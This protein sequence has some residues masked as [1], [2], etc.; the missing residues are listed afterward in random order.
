MKKL[1]ACLAILV[2]VPLLMASQKDV[3]KQAYDPDARVN[4][5]PRIAPRPIDDSRALGDLLMTISLAAI[6]VP[7][8]GFS[9][10]GLTWDGSYLYYEN[11]T[12]HTMYVID[13]T[14]PS[15]VTSW[16]TGITHPWGVGS[17]VNM[18]VTDAVGSPG[19]IYEYTWAGTPTGNSFMSLSGGAVWMGDVSEWYTPGEIA[20]LA[21]G[22]SNSIYTFTV[23]GG[24]PVTS[25]TDPT[26]D[27]I[28]Q[29]AL[30]YDP[31]NHTFWLGGWN[32]GT[33][34]G[35]DAN[36]GAVLR[37]FIPA[38]MSIAGLAYDWQSTLHPT[39]VLWLTTNAATDYIYMLD[40]D[41][42]QPA[43]GIL[44]VDD[45]D[46]AGVSGY[47]ETALDNNGYGYDVW[48][49]TDSG[50]VTPTAAVM[51]AY[52]VVIWTTGDDFSST[53]V[54]TDS[55]EIG[56]FLYGGGK[57]WLSSEDVLWDVGAISWM[58]LSG[59]TSDVG[60]DQAT[61]V[62]PIMTTTSFA[63]TG[64]VFTDYSDW[65][66]P[67]GVSWSEMVNE[68]PDTNTIALDDT[69][70]PYYLF[71][72][73]WPFENIND[74]ADRDT[75]LVR[76]LSWMGMMPGPHDVACSEITSPPDGFPVPAGMY[77]VIGRI[78]NLGSYAE[79]FD[80]TANV[81]DTLD[82]W[83][84]IFSQTVTLTD[85]SIGGDSLVN[86]GTVT[87]GLS[88]YCTEIYTELVDADPSNDTSVIYSSVPNYAHVWDFETGWQ[89][90][91]HTSGQVFPA[92]WAVMPTSYPGGPNWS[93]IPPP[94]AGDSAFIIDSDAAG[95]GGIWV[96][97]TAMSPAVEH[98]GF[99]KL[100]WGVYILYDDLEVLVRRF[101]SG[102]GW[103][104]WF[105]VKFYSGTTGPM[106]DSADV[107]I[108]TGDSMQV[109]FVYDDGASWLW[110]AS[111]DNVMLDGAT[112]ITQEPGTAD[113][114]VFGFAPN[115]S[116]MG[117]SNV[118][119]A[120][121]TTTP[122]HVSLKVYDATGRLVQT[123]VDEHQPIGEKSLVWNNKD[124]NNRAI[125]NGVYFFKLEA[126]GQVDTHK[127]IFVR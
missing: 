121:T 84:L 32:V 120:Y 105:L 73:A 13:P 126:E 79:T 77:D 116:T 106:W 58:H 68:S 4:L 98:I 107:S 122:G 119:I 56:N 6:G 88:D 109:A 20:I 99:T 118:S 92:A 71:F 100:K 65:I 31:H 64:G 83:N 34:W 102:T 113:I 18:W 40:A 51:S 66:Y 7:A 35:V 33:I 86:F 52:D 75:M 55:I 53:F 59:Y 95:S 24:T 78:R 70:E 125:A 62:G 76:V 74:P 82:A 117:R 72:N 63:T 101:E 97:D 67:D 54:G 47:F 46:D 25:I 91:T 27:Y 42:P 23:P 90:W 94:S 114:G 80:V 26:W 29:R 37:Q 111:F 93:Y 2:L 61:G 85:F 124:T 69:Y 11:Q 12:D 17:E 10:A 57:L 19:M 22:G 49:V 96:V 14:G 123:L 43:G 89:G 38:D 110:G 48:I 87:F 112:G 127:M 15:L 9:G 60:C 3:V 21:V 81:Y 30:T 39:P 41:N 5:N 104:S 28:S 115:M 36:T 16:S 8:P 1:A 44:Y 45:D 108:Y 103:S 50:D